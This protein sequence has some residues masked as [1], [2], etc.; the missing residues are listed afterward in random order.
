[1]PNENSATQV[2]NGGSLEDIG[3]YSLGGS[4]ERIGFL[5]DK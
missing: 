3:L 4:K 5:E 1:M 2:E